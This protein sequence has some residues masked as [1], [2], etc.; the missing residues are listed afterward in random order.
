MLKTDANNFQAK[1][2][3]VSKQ[4]PPVEVVVHRLGSIFEVLNGPSG[5][6]D[7]SLLQQLG[8]EIGEKF[9]TMFIHDVLQN[10]VPITAEEKTLFV[11][12]VS[13][14]ISEMEQYLQS[15]GKILSFLS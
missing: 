14:K 3:I 13:Q 10:S 15:T 2:Y 4:S 6:N 1:F 5:E 7:E 9:C 11:Q 12:N 8:A